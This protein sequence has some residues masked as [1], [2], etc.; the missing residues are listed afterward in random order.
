MQQLLSRSE[1]EVARLGGEVDS[2]LKLRHVLELKLVSQQVGASGSPE[3]QTLTPVGRISCP[4]RA[5]SLSLCRL[6][7]ALN[8]M[9]S[10]VVFCA[11]WPQEKRKNA[12]S[13]QRQSGFSFRL[14]DFT[15]SCTCARRSSKS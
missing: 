12:L 6:C 8:H 10:Q 14:S 13:L 4:R 11:R 5:S 15:Q 2:H 9:Q 7:V 1:A 3:S